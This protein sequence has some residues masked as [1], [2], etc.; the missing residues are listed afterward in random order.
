MEKKDRRTSIEIWTLN[1]EPEHQEVL[2]RFIQDNFDVKFEHEENNWKHF[3]VRVTRKEKRRL[4]N[5]IEAFDNYWYTM[6]R[7]GNLIDLYN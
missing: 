1:L 4:L 5:I 7:D 2:E 3:R 6:K